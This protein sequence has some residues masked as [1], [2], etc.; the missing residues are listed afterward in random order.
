[1]RRRAL[2]V[3]HLEPTAPAVA[4]APAAPTTTAAADLPRGVLGF[5]LRLRRVL[6]Q[7]DALLELPQV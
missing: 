4:A 5:W 2:S 6:G 3:I 7:G 1:M